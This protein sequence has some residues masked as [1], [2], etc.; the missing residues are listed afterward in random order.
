MNQFANRL[1]EFANRLIESTTNKPTSQPTT[2]PNGGFPA[3]R[4]R[5][6]SSRGAAQVKGVQEMMDMGGLDDI[7]DTLG[8]HPHMLLI[9]S[10][11]R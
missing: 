11:P 9:P 7:G 1:I 3:C 10:H 5:S 8:A 4:S 2:Q 6:R